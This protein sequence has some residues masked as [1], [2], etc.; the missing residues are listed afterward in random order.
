MNKLKTDKQ[1]GKTS[2]KHR[3]GKRK[4]NSDDDESEEIGNSF[5]ILIDNSNKSDQPAKT[6]GRTKSIAIP[7]LKK[8]RELKSDAELHRDDSISMDYSNGNQKE[9]VPKKSEQASQPPKLQSKIDPDLQK[10]AL[11]S[12]KLDNVL[13]EKFTSVD[14]VADENS[15]KIFEDFAFL[16][17]SKVFSNETEKSSE[18]SVE[19]LY[20]T[21]V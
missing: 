11:I 4:R 7:Y 1:M 6:K 10:I 14:L 12:T 18:N 21:G 15:N 13:K 20:K 3:M 5:F 16:L 17:T 8:K 9:V 19:I 2:T